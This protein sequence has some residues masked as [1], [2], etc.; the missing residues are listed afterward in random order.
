MCVC[1]VFHLQLFT[2]IWNKLNNVNTTISKYEPSKFQI[3]IIFSMCVYLFLTPSLLSFILWFWT[4]LDVVSS[5]ILNVSISIEVFAITFSV[6]MTTIISN[7]IL[8][9]QWPPYHTTNYPYILECNGCFFMV[10]AWFFS[11]IIQ[12]DQKLT[13]T[14]LL[15]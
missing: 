8:N 10:Q 9:P 11:S 14:F 3:H 6:R 12:H 1:S 2:Y 15:F 13:S 5:W 4:F 7:I